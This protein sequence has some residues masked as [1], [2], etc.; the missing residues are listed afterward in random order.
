MIYKFDEYKDLNEGKAFIKRSY[1]DSPEK[2]TYTGV[3]M[4]NAILSFIKEKNQATVQEMGEFVMSL[5]EDIGK[6]PNP[7]WFERNA[8]I[9]KYNKNS[10]GSDY[11]TVTP[12]GEK[13]LNNTNV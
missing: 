8:H 10:N 11:Y 13:V 2:F 7:R 9:I 1:K 5:T 3:K 6:S 4:R 12:L